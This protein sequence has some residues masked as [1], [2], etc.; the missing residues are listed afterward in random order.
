MRD[1]RINSLARQVI[2]YSVHLQPG[3]K[4]LIDVWD[5]AEDFAI[6]L[7]EQ[8]QRAGGQPYVNLQSMAVERAFMLGLDEPTIKGWYEY[9]LNRMKEMDAYVVVRRQEN[10][11]EYADVPEEKKNLYHKYYGLL[12]YGERLTNTKWCVLRY[13]N[14]S[15]A[16]L[17]GMSTEQFEDY[18]FDTCCIDYKKLN[19]AADA[20]CELASKTDKVRITGPDTDITFSVKGLCEPHS[21]CGIFNVPCGETGMPV[22][23]DS[24]N[25]TIHYNLPSTFQGFVFT[26]VRLTLKDGLI[27]E[28]T[29]NNTKLMNEIL[30]TDANARRIGEFAIGFNPAIT[31]PINDTLF[32]EKMTGSLHFT[33]GNSNINPSAI[34]WDLVT[35]QTAEAGGG[36]IWFDDVLIRKDGLFVID[37]LKHLNP[38][39]LLPAVAPRY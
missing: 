15:M 37:S 8:A 34:H 12:H 22:V 17:S 23:T 30:D 9:E 11:N 33:P 21:A 26:D 24:A 28:A 3:E 2:D 29:S 35:L 19:E 32:D 4:I 13:P 18:Y 39:E 5:G 10:I 20:L 38:E 27:V 7:M 31:L 6:A 14:A 36:E 16:Q 1:P 25:G